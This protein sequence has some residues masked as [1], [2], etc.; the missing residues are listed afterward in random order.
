MG[1]NRLPTK[2]GSFI[3]SEGHALIETHI[4]PSLKTSLVPLAF[5]ILGRLSHQAMNSALQS[6]Y[7]LEEKPPGTRLLRLI[8]LTWHER[9]P[10]PYIYLSDLPVGRIWHKVILWEAAHESRLSKKCLIP[11]A[12]LIFGMPQVPSDK[13]SPANQVLSGETTP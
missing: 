3:V 11:S 12:F 9:Q 7:W 6:R 13:L 4:Q 1:L 8:T 2:Q 10:G 5:F